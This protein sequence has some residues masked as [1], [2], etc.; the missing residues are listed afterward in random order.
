MVGSPSDGCAPGPC[1]YFGSTGTTYFAQLGGLRLMDV[2][3]CLT[4][5]AGS[6]TCAGNPRL[7]ARLEVG[8]P[9]IVGGQDVNVIGWSYYSP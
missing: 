2:T 9:G 6:T 7:W 8:T 3:G 5:G 4:S 1:M